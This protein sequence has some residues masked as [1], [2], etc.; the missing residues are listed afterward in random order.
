MTFV[1]SLA[2]V[3]AEASNTDYCFW[4]VHEVMEQGRSAVVGHFIDVNLFNVAV[5]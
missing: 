4:D 3:H 5:G 2:S 1:F